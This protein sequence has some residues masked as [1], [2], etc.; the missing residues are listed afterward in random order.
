MRRSVVLLV[1]FVVCS[2]ALHAQ[3]FGRNKVRYDA[4]DFAVLES[5]HLRVLHYHG[6]EE[7]GVRSARMLE[8]WNARFEKLFDHRL[9]ERQAV[10]LYET[11]A[12]F[13]QTNVVPG[14][15]PQ[16]IAGVTE[17]R[18]GRIV[19]PL[20]AS[21]RTTDHILGHELAHGFHLDMSPGA[22]GSPMLGA[23][24]PLWIIEGIAEYATLGPRDPQTAMW[25]RDAVLRD[26]LPSIRTLSRNLRYNPYRFGHAVLAYI[27]SEFGDDVMSAVYRQSIRQG[28]RRAV[29]DVLGLT[30]AELTE[31]WHA[32]L[33]ELMQPQLDRRDRPDDVGTELFEEQRGLALSPTLSPDGRYVAYFSQPD[34]F[35]FD[36]T[37]A[38]MDTGRIVGRLSAIDANVHFDELRFTESAGRFSPDGSQLAFIVQEAGDIAVAIAS[39]PDLQ[40]RETMRW[41]EVGGITHVGWHPDGERL[42]LS[43]TT[44]GHS[45]LLL[46][47]LADGS[48]R[49][50]TASAYTEL[51]PTYS[52][53]G[54]LLAYLTDRGEDTSLPLLSFGAMKLVVRELET[55][56]ERFITLDGATKHIDPHFS[57]DGTSLYFVADPDGISNVYRQ[58][59]ATG[60]SA[61]MTNVATGVSS[62]TDLSPALT[63]AGRPDTA[64]FSVFTERAFRLRRLDLAELDGAPVEDETRGAADAARLA[65]VA[66][67]RMIV[68]SYLDDPAWGLPD[69]EGFRRE[70]HRP[71]PRLADLGPIAAGVTFTPLGVE[72]YGLMYLGF[73]DLLSDHEISLFLR[74]AGSPRDLGG[75]LAY[76]N[77]Y[78]RLGWGVAVSRDT[79]R[80]QATGRGTRT[81]TLR[82]GTEVDALVTERIIDRTYVDR[83]RLLAEYPLSR[84]VRI[85]GTAGYTRISFLREFQTIA[86][87][88]G[89]NL[90]ERTEVVT[91]E[92]PVHLA[93]G[94]VG[95]VGDYSF[96]GFTGPL[97]GSRFRADLGG[98]AG[99]FSLLTARVDLR[100]YA[101][102]RPI[103]F[104]FR[105]LHTGQYL[106]AD[107]RGLI[108]PLNLSEPNHVRGYEARTFVMTECP[109]GLRECPEYEQI[110]GSRL[111]VA[112][113]EVRLPLF[114][115]E[116]LGLIR[117]RFLPTTL[118]A[119]ADAGIAWTPDDPPEWRWDRA[120]EARVP[121]VGVGGGARFNIMGALIV[122]VYYAYPLQR[123]EQNGYVSIA[124]GAAF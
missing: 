120:P 36:L 30:E 71:R 64:V 51:Q 19:L 13:Q 57:A 69:A 117:F 77:R 43:A 75:Q 23:N 121:V 20:G 100:R 27:G 24:L 18:L 1:A 108:A 56:D 34:I 78:R 21:N 10:I 124:L 39:V 44:G 85:E 90:F 25:L 60:E 109:A 42:I 26:D 67:G 82:D 54:S 41:E 89:R 58:H 8:R 5:D 32:D 72:A 14:A 53:D 65:P 79:F 3:Q 86:E 62:F 2:M 102:L 112:N 15:I 59:L 92:P 66:G 46:V 11:H 113:A 40:V 114:G 110:S 96:A 107:P 97:G 103:A 76:V 74:L 55:G 49:P 84:N 38:E 35:S 104:A 48:I 83:P 70:D 4:F 9:S 94:G 61:R 122:Q 33:V 119:F 115:T 29:R 88:G 93:Q 17:D 73:T 16:G 81:V 7:V 28:F 6:L 95:L 12:D 45:N 118:F 116:Q 37:V 106:K 87:A 98:S 52:P 63:V 123:P 80:Q 47:E 101:F 50:L 68:A 31:R 105:V 99:T 111:L 91:P 22:F